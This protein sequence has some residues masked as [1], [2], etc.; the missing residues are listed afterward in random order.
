MK[1]LVIL[2]VLGTLS[3]L[4]HAQE[5]PIIILDQLDNNSDTLYYPTGE[6]FATYTIVDMIDGNIIECRSYYKNGSLKEI[7][8]YNS[9][10]EK[11]GKWKSWWETGEIQSEA[12]YQ[13]DIRHGEWKFYTE[14]G[15]LYSQVEYRRGKLKEGVF[16]D[17]TRGLLVKN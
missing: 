8:S 10:G 7:G 17:E 16:Y 9:Y 12:S 11:I 15:L 14:A 3:L 2:I 4:S 13:Q 6:V 1:K 5:T